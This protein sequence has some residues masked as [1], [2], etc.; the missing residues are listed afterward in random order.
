MLSRSASKRKTGNANAYIGTWQCVIQENLA[1]FAVRKGY[2]E[3][4]RKAEYTGG[5][6]MMLHS[7]AT[8]GFCGAWHSSAGPRPLRKRTRLREGAKTAMQRFLA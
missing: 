1:V 8:S 3:E 6:M 7:P 5:R 2:T 4:V